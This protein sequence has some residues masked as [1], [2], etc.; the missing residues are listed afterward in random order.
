MLHS[1]YDSGNLLR[2]LIASCPQLRHLELTCGHKPSFQLDTFSKALR[3]FPKLR[4][5]HLTI[6]KYT[7]ESLSA[8]AEH[9]AKTNPRL[10]RFSLTLL[11]PTYPLPLPFAIP[12]FPFSLRTRDTGFFMLTCDHHGLP[13]TLRAFERRRLI[14][15]LGLG[16]TLRMRRYVRD[17]RPAG[18]PARRKAG[19]KAMLSLLNDGSTAG[20][21]MRLLLFCVFLV[22]LAFWGFLSNA[23]RHGNLSSS[24]SL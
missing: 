21:E 22:C 9:I 14:W 11:P 13:L 16:S 20:E 2:S 23:R 4:V 12:L 1:M 6:I 8:G 17:L 3:G 18:S 19:F 7:G 10:E 15:P 24:T 5:L